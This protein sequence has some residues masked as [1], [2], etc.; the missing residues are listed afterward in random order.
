MRKGDLVAAL[1][2]VARDNRISIDVTPDGPGSNMDSERAGLVLQEV[3]RVAGTD[4]CF[5]KAAADEPLFVLRP[6]DVVAPATVR[7]WV[8]RVHDLGGDEQKLLGA[9]ECASAM[10][11]WQQV[12]PDRVKT[13]D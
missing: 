12:N 2:R 6:T 4:P 3:F 7:D 10:E 5:V 1:V 13:P 8:G 9:M 11:R